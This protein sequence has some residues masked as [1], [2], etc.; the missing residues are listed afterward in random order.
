MLNLVYFHYYHLLNLALLIKKNYELEGE[1]TALLVPNSCEALVREFGLVRMEDYFLFD[2]LDNLAMP[3]INVV[4]HHY[5]FSLDK[6]PFFLEKFSHKK[7][8]FSFYADGFTNVFLNQPKRKE[9]LS[10]TGAFHRDLIFFDLVNHQF[11]SDNCGFDLRVCDSRLNADIYNASFFGRE[12]S[13]FLDQNSLDGPVTFFALR[14]WGSGKF[15]GGLYA[16][17][18]GPMSLFDVVFEQM[19][20]LELI[21]PETQLLFRKDMRDPDFSDSFCSLFQSS[22]ANVICLDDV[23]RKNFVIDAFLYHL[24][25]GTSVNTFSFDSTLPLSF[26][27]LG[28]AGKF[29]VGLDADLLERAGLSKSALQAICM[30]VKSLRKHCNEL[31]SKGVDLCIEEFSETLFS[32]RVGKNDI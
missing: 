17:P 11:D 15:H 19:S 6:V 7:V 14:P 22:A 29:F 24:M 1:T 16:M 12:F 23:I 2:D 26:L 5:D 10:T 32:V 28:I 8:Y 30:K 27:R 3:E 9:I 18:D 21:R 25:R 4:L 13:T 20:F 31:I